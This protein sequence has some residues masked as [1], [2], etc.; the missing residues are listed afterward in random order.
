MHALCGSCIAQEGEIG[1]PVSVLL[2]HRG[3][4]SFLDFHKAVPEILVTSSFDGT[5]RLWSAVAGGGC[6]FQLRAAA[7]QIQPALVSHSLRSRPLPEC[8][9]A[10]VVPAGQA[11]A[12]SIAQD[13]ALSETSTP[14]PDQAG[15]QP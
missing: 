12:G 3:P 1:T 11:D 7:S 2:G 5:C 6:L 15:F 9:E 13:E 10:P 4:V 8:D 14:Q